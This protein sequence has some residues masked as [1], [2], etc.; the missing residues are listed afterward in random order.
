ML[1]R[2]EAYRSASHQEGE[3]LSTVD[4]LATYL[5]EIGAYP[6]L[7]IEEEAVLAKRMRAGDQDAY[8]KLVCSNLRF[9][10]SVARRYQYRGVPLADLID[11]GN[12]G[13][14]RAVHGFDESKGG[15]CISYAVWWIRQ[16]IVRALA[17]HGHAMRVPIGREGRLRRMGRTAELLRQQLQREPT[18]AELAEDLGISEG[19]VDRTWGIGIPSVS[20]DALGADGQDVSLM[21]RIADEGAPPD[22]P[23]PGV[24]RAEYIERS[25][26]L[27]RPREK[28]VLRNYFGLDRGDPMTL[29][30]IGT[31]LGITRERVR[32]IK[33]KALRRLRTASKGQDIE[34][35]L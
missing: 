19:E 27:L 25:M 22:A 14:M 1:V 6:L 20:L 21:E 29:E 24:D 9:V 16:A 15:K 12:I 11:E 18:R 8:D 2:P 17:D 5:R 34:S 7:S 3:S 30:E 28:A 26:D 4:L 13:L 35:V 31:E 23:L 32:Q 33:E 10:V